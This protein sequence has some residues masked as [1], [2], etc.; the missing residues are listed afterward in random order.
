VSKQAKSD[1]FRELL[2]LLNSGGITL[3]Q[4]D[5][6]V[7]QLAGLERVASRGRRDTISHPPHGHDDIANAV[8][9]AAAVAK[10]GTWDLDWVSYDSEGGYGATW[11]R[12]L[13]WQH[14]IPPYGW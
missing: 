13:Y 7:A 11:R 6:L 3:P 12:M 4:H 8:A 9:G 1:L 2:P 5:R 10:R 14:I